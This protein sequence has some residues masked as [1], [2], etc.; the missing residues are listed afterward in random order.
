[1]TIQDTVDTCPVCDET[2]SGIIRGFDEQ[3]T[4]TDITLQTD[5][6]VCVTIEESLYFIHDS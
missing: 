2:I 1:M 6:D 5:A 4:A 3:F